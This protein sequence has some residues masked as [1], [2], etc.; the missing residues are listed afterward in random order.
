MQSARV[1]AL[2]RGRGHVSPEDVTDLAADVLRHRIVLSY[3]A[4]SEGITADDLLED[5]IAAV[6]RRRRGGSGALIGGRPERARERRAR[7]PAARQGPGPIPQPVVEAIEVAVTGSFAGAASDRRAAGV[8]LGTELAQLRPYDIGDDVRRIDPA[9][10]ARTGQP[11]VRLHV[12]ER[13]LTTWIALD[14]S[15][16]WP[17]ARRGG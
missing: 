10:T 11:H 13:A 16:R 5:V 9:A 15:P 17:L 7:P 6:V 4:L 8:G 1:L 12:P 3:D 2:L 14:V